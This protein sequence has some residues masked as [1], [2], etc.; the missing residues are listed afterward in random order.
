MWEIRKFSYYKN[1][2][3]PEAKIF[4]NLVR[5]WWIMLFGD[6]IPWPL[7]Q[8]FGGRFAAQ[9]FSLLQKFLHRRPLNT[10]FSGPHPP[11]PPLPTGLGE[12]VCNKPFW[13]K[14][15]Y[16]CTIG[17]VLKFYIDHVF[18]RFQIAEKK[19]SFFLDSK[20]AYRS[21]LSFDFSKLFCV[22]WRSSA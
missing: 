14:W 5:L 6:S 15:P 7:L 17:F 13:E 22:S 20:V 1:I 3:P 9:I 4:E 8:N 18:L 12:K 16:E 19:R 2:S 11:H 21:I 10:E